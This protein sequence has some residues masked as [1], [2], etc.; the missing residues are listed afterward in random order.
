[1]TKTN[2]FLD[3]WVNMPVRLLSEEQRN[4]F[5]KNL[6]YESPFLNE[7]GS[8]KTLLLYKET[9]DYFSLPI[10]WTKSRFPHVFKMADDKR[11]TPGSITYSKLPD[12]F[13][14]SVKDPEGQKQFMEDLLNAAKEH[15]NVLAVAKTGSGKTVCALRTAALLNHRT[16]VLVDKD[17]L[18]EQWIREIQDKLG[19]SRDRIG[20]IQQNQCEYEDKD[21]VIGLLQTNAR[22]DY[23]D[24]VYNAF[25]TVIV[26]EAD[27]IATEFFNEVLPRFNARYRILLT[28][29]PYRK[30]GS[31]VTMF[32]HCGEPSVISQADVLPVKVHVWKYYKE[33]KL[34]G[35]DENQ[36]VLAISK[37]KD[38]N[39]IIASKILDCYKAGR[40]ILVVA[41]KI[42][43]IELL[44]QLSKDLG[45]P[46]DDMG[47]FT[48]EVSK[49]DRTYEWKKVGRRKSTSEELETAKTKRI[50]YATIGMV[51]RAVDVPRWDTLIEAAPFWT[52][53]QLLGRI[54]RLH[55]G[56][57]Y[58][59]AFSWRHMKSSY[60]E[61]RY[62]SRYKE[63]IEC[64]AQVISHT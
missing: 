23:S 31:D 39:A 36:Q 12:P 28:A 55:K 7:D 59:I 62:Y 38:F 33:G 58:P 50:V 1:M 29:T 18:K 14:P 4:E 48:A 52:G 49:Y 63:W 3:G 10:D 15:E 27:V 32:Y 25:G 37:D 34:W 8:R 21:I 9:D 60:A 43:H 41:E 13:H 24:D 56:K 61:Q 54:R 45:I 19:V 11:V 53:A 64:G 16:L 6:T 51:R 57:K 2:L 35:R 30:D 5:R 46:S 20:I 26:D 44:M 47:Q 40:N 42:D 22:R 17:N